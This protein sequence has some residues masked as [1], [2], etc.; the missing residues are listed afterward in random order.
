MKRVGPLHI[1][2]VVD[3]DVLVRHSTMGGVKSLTLDCAWEPFSPS[4]LLIKGFVPGFFFNLFISYHHCTFW[5]PTHSLSPWLPPLLLWEDEGPLLAVTQPWHINFLQGQAHPFPLKPDK[6]AHLGEHIPLTDKS[7]TDRS[8]SSYSSYWRIHMKTWL[9]ISLI[10]M[11]KGRRS[12]S[13][14][15]FDWCVSLWE[16]PRVQISWFFWFSCGVPIPFGAPNPSLNISRIV[17]EL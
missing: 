1:P 10:H 3:I 14:M 6:A 5:S 8:G 17:P 11:L 9:Y 7:S 13:C 12:K 2:I 4:G 16:F 15:L